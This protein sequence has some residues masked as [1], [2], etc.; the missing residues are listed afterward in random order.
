[1]GGQHASKPLKVHSASWQKRRGLGIGARAPWRTG[2]QPPARL[3]P[4]RLQQ[5]EVIAVVVATVAAGL[6]EH[7][8]DLDDRCVSLHPSR[9][10]AP[11]RFAQGG[12][13][14]V[15]G[16][17]RGLL[18]EAPTMIATVL[19]QSDNRRAREAEGLS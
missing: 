2:R 17:A 1:M 7:G 15:A 5:G 13:S 12:M 4:V 3:S 9:T 10:G 11:W 8:E 18:Q 6:I 19:R 16:K 14:C